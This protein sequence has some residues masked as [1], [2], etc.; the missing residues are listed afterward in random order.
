MADDSSGPIIGAVVGV[1]VVLF[2]IFILYNTLYII[3]QVRSPRSAPS[4]TRAGAA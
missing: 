1:A 4:F 3:K 2:I